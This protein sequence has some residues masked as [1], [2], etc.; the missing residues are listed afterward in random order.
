MSRWLALCGLAAMG[1]LAALALPDAQLNWQAQRWVTEPW[2]LVTAAFVH[3]PGWH[4]AANL[5]ALALL[6]WAGWRL[7][8]PARDALAWALA[9]PLAHA[10]LALLPGLAHYGGLSGWLHAGVAIVALRLIADG[11]RLGWLW[12]AALALKLLLEAPWGPV[13]RT[14]PGWPMPVVPAAHALG[15]LAGVLAWAGVSAERRWRGL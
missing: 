1:T 2:R 6:A 9:W 8:L 14:I 15:A 5:G 10:L 3:G 13:V 12:L 7:N 4:R 11:Q